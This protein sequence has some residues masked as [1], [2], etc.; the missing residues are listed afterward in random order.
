M[1]N[2]QTYVLNFIHFE[3]KA[4]GLNKKQQVLVKENLFQPKWKKSSMSRGY[5]I[6][7]SSNERNFNI[8]LLLKSLNKYKDP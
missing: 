4:Y 6:W 1:K 2:L 5:R 7:Y 3:I 8:V